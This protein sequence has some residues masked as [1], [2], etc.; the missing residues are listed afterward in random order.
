MV[1]VPKSQI[2]PIFSFIE[3]STHLPHNNSILSHRY[4]LSFEIIANIS[5]SGTDRY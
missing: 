5:D 1:I 3:L 2:F 4:S